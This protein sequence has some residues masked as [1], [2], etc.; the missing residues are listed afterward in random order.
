MKYSMYITFFIIC[1]FKSSIAACSLCLDI[2]GTRI[3]AAI[4]KPNMTLE[5]IKHVKVITM[6]AEGWFSEKLPTLFDPNNTDGLTNRVNCPFDN[7]LFG[8]SG[9]VCNRSEYINPNIKGIPRFLKTECEKILKKKVIFDIDT[10]IW[11]CG[12][13]YWNDLM[14]EKIQY[15]CLGITLGTGAGVATGPV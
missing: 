3:K 9:P 15:P 6:S 4:L 14:G 1:F 7:V 8:I 12:A 5:Q 2:G 11:S 10:V 13:L